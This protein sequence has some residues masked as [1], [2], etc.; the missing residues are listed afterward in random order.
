MANSADP[1]QFASQANWSG[2]SLFAKAGYIWVPYMPYLTLWDRISQNLDHLEGNSHKK[3]RIS[4][5][6]QTIIQQILW[7]NKHKSHTIVV[8]TSS[9]HEIKDFRLYLG[10]SKVMFKKISQ[11]FVKSPLKFCFISQ[12]F[13]H[14]LWHVWGSEG[15]GLRTK[16]VL[17][18]RGFP[19]NDSTQTCQLQCLKYGISPKYWDTLT[20]YHNCLKIWKSLFHYLLMC[21]Q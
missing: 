7:R 14:S 3:I 19:C 13:V 4:Q 5:N 17:R 10:S 21:L 18:D 9:V 11:N 16:Q 8:F 6:F 12:I 20:P 15:Q 2:S 1:D